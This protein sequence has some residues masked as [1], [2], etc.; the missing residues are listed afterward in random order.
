M[1]TDQQ[2]QAETLY[3]Q[4][5]LT[6][7]EIAQAVGVS[8]RTLHYWVRQNH[9]DT[10]R[11]SSRAMPVYLAG[12]CYIILAR[13][14]ENILSRTDSPVTVQEVNAMY[15][16]TSTIDRLNKRGALSEQL[17]TLTHFMEFTHN[18]DPQLAGDLQPVVGAFVSAQA[19][20]KPMDGHVSAPGEDPVEKQ[21]DLEDLAAWQAGEQAAMVTGAPVDAGH[22]KQTPAQAKQAP[23]PGTMPPPS[24]GL[25]RAARRAMARA[26]A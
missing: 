24:P 21:M 12:N 22:L 5:G 23:K 4:T 7:T 15:K 16:L 19:A 8:R 1:K 13:L 25:N 10:I 2:K 18:F 26:A 14:Q 11:E 9:W 20:E 6:K 3:F 17:E